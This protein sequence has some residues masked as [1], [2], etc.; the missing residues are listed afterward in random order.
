MVDNSEAMTMIKPS[1]E[2]NPAISEAVTN[3][4]HSSDLTSLSALAHQGESTR[5]KEP[6][7]KRPMNAF[8]L[9]AQ[10]ARRKVATK[11]PNLNYAKLSKTLGKI[12]QVLPEEE[13]RPFIEEAERLRTQHKLQHP[14]YKYTPKRLKS[15]KHQG[16]AMKKPRFDNLKP[17]ELFNIIQAKC[18]PSSN[19]QMNT[20]SN[21]LSTN[22]DGNFQMFYDNSLYA[23]QTFDPLNSCSPTTPLSSYDND[24]QGLDY[25]GIPTMGLNGLNADIPTTPNNDLKWYIPDYDE[26]RLLDA[27]G[28]P[29]SL[30]T[31]KPNTLIANQPLSAFLDTKPDTPTSFTQLFPSSTFN[32][33]LCFSKLTDPIENISSYLEGKA[34]MPGYLTV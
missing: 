2:A 29:N 24:L 20:H 9:Y 16:A 31:P 17:Q 33:S 25:L 12:W 19:Y 32:E 10:V 1:Y 7:V 6:R 8:M 30:L 14:D 34:H 4:L 26:S 23:G 13:R 5:D 22:Y 3:I 15:K 11:Y 18:D 28:N 21:G 27:F